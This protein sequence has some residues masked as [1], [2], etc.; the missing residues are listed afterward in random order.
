M[1]L[2]SAEETALRV[3]LVAELQGLQCYDLREANLRLLTH[4]EGVLYLVLLAKRTREPMTRLQLELYSAMPIAELALRGDGKICLLAGHGAHPD[5]IATCRTPTT[6]AAL[7][8]LI[9]Q[10]R[11]RAWEYI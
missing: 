8:A 1:D 3:Q 6:P 2:K 11:V 5:T 9:A 7:A 4:N 10:W